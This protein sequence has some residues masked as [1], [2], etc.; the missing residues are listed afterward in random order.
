MK[1]WKKLNLI[2]KIIVTV[3]ILIF[4]IFL[5]YKLN[6]NSVTD[7]VANDVIQEEH[8]Q[9]LG[10]DLE[11]ADST[12]EPNDKPE[13]IRTLVSQYMEFIRMSGEDVQE[14]G[15][16][17][18]NSQ[19]LER[20]SEYLQSSE[21]LARQ[22]I[23]LYE[24]NVE[25]DDLSDEWIRVHYSIESANSSLTT[26]YDGAVSAMSEGDVDSFNEL[27]EHYE[28]AAETLGHAAEDIP[29]AEFLLE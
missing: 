8:D 17:L 5:L 27:L 19:D 24:Q 15:Q 22:A 14:A 16:V 21:E 12:E 18:V 28:F 20:A 25:V 4:I 9:D 1:E 2:E 7:P 6:D 29:P 13:E 23:D 10:N 26:F 3:G 11:H